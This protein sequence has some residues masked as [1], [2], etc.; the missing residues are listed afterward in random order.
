MIAA[1][2]RCRVAALM[3]LLLASLLL[4]RPAHAQVVQEP[5]WVEDPLSGGTGYRLGQGLALGDGWNLGG[6]GEWVGEDLHGEPATT[7][8]D[9]LSAFVWW[10]D[11]SERLRFFSEFELEDAVALDR[12]GLHTQ[13]AELA[14]ERFHL[15]YAMSDLF[16]FRFGKF[17]TP[18]GRWNTLHA[19]PLTWTTSRPLITEAT[20]PTSATGAM[21]HGTLPWLGRALDYSVYASPGKQLATESDEDNFTEAYGLRLGFGAG[22]PLQFG[23]SLASFEQENAPDVRKNLYAADLQWDWHRWEVSGEYALR[24]LSGHEV[25]TDETGTYLQVVAPIT[26]KLYGVTRVEG[27][28]QSGTTDGLH[29]YLVG[30]TWRHS[31]ALVLKSEYR[32]ATE[33]HIAAPVGFEASLAVMF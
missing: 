24:S 10:Q 18:I 19:A 17:L 2:A 8:L 1:L 33:N 9:S 6:Y 29:L 20:F 16:Q 3:C 25:S 22:T 14:L 13:Y 23:V 30:L 27:F 28:Q 32:W 5:G 7:R 4:V 26:E 31:P 12:D 21:L 15:D 11:P